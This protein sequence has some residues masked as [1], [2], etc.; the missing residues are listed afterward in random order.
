MDAGQLPHLDRLRQGDGYRRLGTT[1]PPQTPVAFASFITGTNPGG[2]GIFDFI[3][4]DPK[5]YSV[6]FS[7]AGTSRGLGAWEVG[8]HRLPL[9]FWPF[10]HEAQ[11]PRLH[12]QGVPFWD[13]LDEAHA[14]AE[15]MGETLSLEKAVT[16]L[17]GQVHPGAMRYYKEKGIK[18]PKPFTLDK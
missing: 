11:E 9:T 5:D 1:I 2:H 16:A 3:R 8:E 15:Y 17:A 13:H 10:N 4:R 7:A 6:H 18:V 12:R 14:M